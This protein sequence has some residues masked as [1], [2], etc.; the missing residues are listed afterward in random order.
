ME[1]LDEMEQ[2]DKDRF[3]SVCNYLLSH[4]FL[5]RVVFRPNKGFVNNPDYTF[6]VSHFHEIKEY[7]SFLDWDMLRN[8]TDGYIML[9]N[10]GEANCMGLSKTET[11]ALLLLR[12]I[13]QEAGGE[14]LGAER[15]AEGTLKDFVEKCQ[16]FLELKSRYEREKMF[17]ALALFE[18]HNLIQRKRGTF[19]DTECEFFILP[20][21]VS[22]VP[23]E[24]LYEMVSSLEKEAAEKEENDG[25]QDD[26]EGSEESPSD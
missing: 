16:P 22:A 9:V 7:L 26:T 15:E 12:L 17:K 25:S 1:W 13:Y 18:H 11:I 19:K 21:I 8:E 20:T 10:T 23:A 5:N 14:R 3:K 2:K 24:R 6:A 4:T